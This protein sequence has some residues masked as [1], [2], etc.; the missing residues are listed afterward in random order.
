M[1][2]VPAGNAG[3]VGRR[4][5]GGECGVW[6]PPFPPSLVSG[7]VDQTFLTRKTL[8]RAHG[9]REAVGLGGLPDEEG[10]AERAEL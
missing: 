3:K 8:F 6:G 9:F 7:A 2:G 1:Q 10:G 4:K 5:G